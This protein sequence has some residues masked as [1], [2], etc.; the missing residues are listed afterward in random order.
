MAGELSQLTVTLRG[1]ASHLASTFQKANAD[2]E[3]FGSKF[4][5]VMANVGKAAVAG[6]SVAGVAIAGIAV[7][8]VADFTT[9]SDKMREVWTLL[10]DMSEAAFGEMGDNV[11]E[12]SKTFGVLPNEV[13]PAL[14][15]S[16]SAGVPAENVFTFLETAQKAA[17]GGV[18]DLTTAVNGISSVVN[19]YGADVL[20]AGQASDL[21][22]T[23]VK[24]GKTTFGELSQSLFNVTPVAS[25]LGVSFGQVTAAIASMTAQGVPTSVATTQIRQALIEMSKEGGKTADLFEQL[26]GKSFK[27]FI[28]AGGTVQGALQLLEEHA[29][30]TGVGV[31]DL[32]GSVEAGGAALALTGKGTE[33][34]SRNLEAMANSAGA[35]DVAF[36]KMQGG[37]GASFNKVRAAVAVALI[38][39]GERLAPTVKQLADNVVANMPLIASTF[40]SVLSGVGSA[41]SAALPVIKSIGETL[42]SVLVPAIKDAAQ[43]VQDKLIPAFQDFAQ[44]DVLPKVQQ[45][46]EVLRDQVLPAVRDLAEAVSSTLGPALIKVIGFIA[47]HK[48]IL[49]GV[50]VVIAGVLVAAFTSWAISAGA[51]AVATIAATAPVIAIGAAIALLVA[52]II[53]LVQHWDELSA[54]Y[55]V[56]AAATDLVGDAIRRLRDVAMQLADFFVSNVLPVL[57]TLGQ[58]TFPIV[59]AAAGILWGQITALV[60]GIQAISGAVQGAIGWLGNLADTIGNVASKLP[61][62]DAITK[63]SPVPLAEGIKETAAAIRTMTA[64]MSPWVAALSEAKIALLNTEPFTAQAAAIQANIKILEA[65][66][67]KRREAITVLKEHVAGLEAGRTAAEGFGFAMQQ[68]AE[69]GKAALDLSNAFAKA[70]L[71][72]DF[73]SGQALAGAVQKMIDAARKAG[74]E[75]AGLL[76][77]DLQAAIAAALAEPSPENIQ[78]AV[79]LWNQLGG[80]MDAA[81]EERG[82][83]NADTFGKALSAA[84]ASDANLNRIGADGEKLMDA[85]AKAIEKGGEQSI[86]ALGKVAADVL[87]KINNL[88]A[89]FADTLYPAMQEALDRAVVEPGEESLNNLRAVLTRVNEV[90]IL[91]PKGF[92]QMEAPTKA[93]ILRIVQ[94]V[95]DGSVLQEDAVKR[96]ADVTK[97]IGD[98]FSSLPPLVQSWVT[99]IAAAIEAGEPG[100]R[101]AAARFG[102]VSNLIGEDFAKLP[103]AA[104]SAIAAVVQA[105]MDGAISIGQAKD[106]IAEINKAITQST[107]QMAADVVQAMGSLQQN[108]NTVFGPSSMTG[109]IG[110]NTEH[111]PGG[112]TKTTYSDG[113]TVYNA[114]PGLIG[115]PGGSTLAGSAE[116]AARLAGISGLTKASQDI[117]EAAATMREASRAQEI[118]AAINSGAA[119]TLFEAGGALSGT[120]DHFGGS[121]TNFGGSVDKFGESVNKDSEARG[122]GDQPRINPDLTPGAQKMASGGTIREHIWGVGASGRRYEFGESGIEHVIPSRDLKVGASGMQ[123]RGDTYITVPIDLSAARFY[124]VGSNEVRAEFKDM[125]EEL[126]RTGGIAGVMPA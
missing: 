39:I 62:L 38:E 24:Q 114:H 123:G 25:A 89:G 117:I 68:M 107:Q 22:F 47:D 102:K 96:I 32:F 94:A 56:L 1:D 30:R 104:Q 42:L 119:L 118:T 81:A 76:G 45:F 14:Y 90:T 111:L 74:V 115:T 105:Y 29:K 71:S 9:F 44:N 7:K 91:I 64:E 2:T 15:Q 18:T 70:L 19:A 84:I 101:A 75:G 125:I 82:T 110:V 77:H 63:R 50:A 72:D 78:A 13:I 73:A 126:M 124:G 59:A 6:A 21:M 69:G 43:W 11:K 55:P 65:E 112:V 34:F 98:N 31:N 54:R 61:G 20:S 85:L 92:E 53:Y 108:M 120:A 121:T 66:I 40:N 86:A 106:Q 5:G 12:F 122:A 116:E 67:A 46:G 28:D 33:T 27:A 26:A 35:T 48:E 49:A 58:F 10:P 97:L 36:D 17:A 87:G 52:G 23:A 109:T 100:A 103:P 79:D 3:G 93:A 88:P 41:V 99:K 57:T 80:A 95:Q 8:G 60:G 113:T 4:G 37:I 16:I 51:A 83:L